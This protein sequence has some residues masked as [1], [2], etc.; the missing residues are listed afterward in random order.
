MSSKT[1]RAASALKVGARCGE[2]WPP[3]RRPRPLRAAPP[4]RTRR[5]VPAR[6]DVCD[7]GPRGLIAAAAGP[8][9]AAWC[10]AARRCSVPSTAS[11]RTCPG[12][13]TSWSSSS[14]TAASRARPST[15]RDSATCRRGISRRAGSA[16]CAPSDALRW[17]HRSAPDPSRA[18]AAR[19]ALRQVPAAQEQG[20]HGQALRQ[21]C[22]QRPPRG[23][24]A[25]L[26]RPT[27]PAACLRGACRP[28]AAQHALS[29]MPRTRRRG[30]QLP[31][32]PGHVRPGVLRRRVLRGRRR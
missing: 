10:W 28:C 3:S 11:R 31:H 6:A 16:R 7:R 20:P 13:W 15:V 25:T 5:W 2:C 18:L 21:R 4:P 22:V 26:G 8:R 9:R 1:A 14:P 17:A 29:A 19:S 23:R 24:P 27:M 12:P 30:G 32:A